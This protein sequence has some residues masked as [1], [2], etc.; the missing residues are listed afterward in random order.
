MVQGWCQFPDGQLRECFPVVV[1]DAK[2][3]AMYR[4]DSAGQDMYFVL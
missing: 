4:V 3:Y 1:L 2:T